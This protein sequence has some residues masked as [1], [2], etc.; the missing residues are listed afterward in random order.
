MGA[1]RTFDSGIFSNVNKVVTDEFTVKMIEIDKLI[2]NS[3]NFYSM[4]EIEV[5]AEDIERQGL[6]HNL[7]VTP[8]SNGQ[9]KI[10]SGHR[11]YQAVIFLRQEG[12]YLSLRLPCFVSNEKS[13][14][15]QMQDLIMLN[16]T[17][18]EIS[19]S[20][21]LKQYEH[22]K[23]ILEARKENGEKFGRIREKIAEMLKVSVGQISK[24][25][26]IENNAVDEVKQAIEDGSLSIS[27]ANEIAKLDEDEQRE[28]I[29]DKDIS[30]IT[31]KE[32]KT[33]KKQS[34]AN[35]ENVTYVSQNSFEDDTNEDE[36]EVMPPTSQNTSEDTDGEN[37]TYVSQNPPDIKDWVK[38]TLHAYLGYV[39]Q[40]CEMFDYS[41]DKTTEFLDTFKTLFREQSF[42]EAHK[43]YRESRFN[44]HGT[45]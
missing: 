19:D 26:H 37:V 20:E 31:H 21:R 30:E 8:V 27:T 33:R 4:S 29:K 12:R 23:R 28:L 5:L 42:E 14:D 41:D 45:V 15:E 40:T 38:E 24:I 10:I 25:E 22:L 43:Y 13:D 7:V 18:R 1:A 6:K 17:G 2:P 44:A 39:L 3:E 16:V 9:Y 34:S 35:K 32:V 11:R 36:Y